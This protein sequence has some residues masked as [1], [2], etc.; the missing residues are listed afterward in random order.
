MPT[1]H[2]IR[3][4]EVIGRW[5][6]VMEAEQLISA[7]RSFAEGDPDPE[8]KSRLERWIE[9]GNLVE[10]ASAMDGSLSFGTAG[11][12]GV[13]GPGPSRMNLATVAVASF[14]LV[15]YLLETSGDDTSVVIGF[16]GRPD[17]QRF[18]R[19]VAEVISG[20]GAQ[21]IL[22][23][24]MTATPCI[25]Y[26]VRKLGASAGVVVTASHNPRGDNG[27]K[28]FDRDGVQIVGPFDEEVAKR[29]VAA[30]RACDIARTGTRITQLPEDALASYFEDARA[31]AQAIVPLPVAT[32]AR[33]TVPYSPLHGVGLRGARRVLRGLEERVELSPVEQQAEPDGSFPTAPFPNPEEP[34]VL[35]LLISH[36]R[37]LGADFCCANDPDA[38]RFALCLPL[39]GEGLGRLSGD[40]LGLLFA[41]ACLRTTKIR[42]PEVI[43]TVVSSPALTLLAEK[44]GARTTQTLTGFKWLCHAAL[45]SDDFVFAYEEALGYCFAPAQGRLGALDKDGLLALLVC[46]RLLLQAGGGAAL[47]GRLLE[48]YREVGLWG[49]F[50]QSRRFEGP[51]ALDRMV[52]QMDRLRETPDRRIGG[53]VVARSIDYREQAEHRPWYLGAQDLVRFD[54]EA[55]G[56]MPGAITHGR[57][58]IRPS[59]TEPKL[60]AYVHLHSEF[61]DESEYTEKASEQEAVAKAIARQVLRRP[62]SIMPPSSK[63]LRG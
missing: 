4:C 34:G 40:A 55:E 43:S 31:T 8:T 6:G 30:P 50:G 53:M 36:A 20:A 59:G 61:A 26:A 52:T 29:M 58:F 15:S 63:M 35:D 27:F 13:V 45:E 56:E 3:Y 47:A 28:V 12:R 60:K 2:A 11:L 22:A 37:T 10:L 21:A 39:A 44:Y 41:D 49:S 14:G 38:D 9:E 17:S 33:L 32:E 57:V 25:A 24:T 19:C 46:V 7:A 51:G 62:E 54:L 42:N 18:A 48:I 23:D 1:R 5:P 16:D